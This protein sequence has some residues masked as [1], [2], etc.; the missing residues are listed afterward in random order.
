MKLSVNGNKDDS[1]MAHTD[2]WGFEIRQAEQVWFQQGP[3]DLV[4]L[5]NIYEGTNT[6]MTDLHDVKV[7]CQCDVLW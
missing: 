1:T 4:Q 5:I 7:V 6:P 2:D 3:C